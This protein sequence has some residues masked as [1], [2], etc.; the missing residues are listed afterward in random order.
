MRGYGLF[1]FVCAISLAAGPGPTA[2]RPVAGV[3]GFAYL[4]VTWHF[5]GGRGVAVRP[6][7]IYVRRWFRFHFIPWPAVKVFR[8]ARP[9]LSPT[10]Y[11]E[12]TSGETRPLPF[13]QGRQVSW[14]D[15]KSRDAVTVLNR[16]LGLARE[17]A[18]RS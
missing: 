8:V 1:G 17:H 11:V 15:G 2:L 12:L 13:T 7:G 14:K 3:I 10:V 18:R 5:G 9:A 6:D 4:Y 16:E